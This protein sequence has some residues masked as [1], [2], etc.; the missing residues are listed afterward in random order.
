[1]EFTIIKLYHT[2]TIRLVWSKIFKTV[3][4]T[5]TL[6]MC[7]SF[8][9]GIPYQVVVR[10]RTSMNNTYHMTTV[11][12]YAASLQLGH[13]LLYNY[14]LIIEEGTSPDGERSRGVIM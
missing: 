3:N 10:V 7:V 5:P 12:W 9:T 4:G 14:V 6:S 13:S 1:M 11:P 8:T 2:R